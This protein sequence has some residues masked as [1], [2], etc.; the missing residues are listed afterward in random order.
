MSKMLDIHD[1]ATCTADHGQPCGE[2]RRVRDRER[3]PERIY[4]HPTNADWHA[5]RRQSPYPWRSDELIEYVRADLAQPAPD[6]FPLESPPLRSLAEAQGDAGD[7]GDDVSLE[8]LAAGRAAV[9]APFDAEW[10]KAPAVF[11]SSYSVAYHWW[12]RGR[13]SNREEVARLLELDI[14]E[15]GRLL[16]EKLR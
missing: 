6:P 7:A 9:I 14:E 13:T 3:G 5:V 1:S 10:A 4:V 15:V 16:E 8:L 12:L 11:K 2:C